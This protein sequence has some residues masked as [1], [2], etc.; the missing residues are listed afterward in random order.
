[1]RRFRGKAPPVPLRARFHLHLW[2]SLHKLLLSCLRVNQLLRYK[3]QDR[4]RYKQ[5]ASSCYLQLISKNIQKVMK[6]VL[7]LSSLSLIDL[8]GF[9][10]TVDNGKRAVRFPISL[11]ST[12]T[13]GARHQCSSAAAETIDLRTRQ[14][15]N[16]C[17]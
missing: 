10:L 13:S 5:K 17:Y 4:S 12:Q 9:A 2:D 1:M 3:I 15:A 8:I 11:L 7:N 14:A 6:T 16:N